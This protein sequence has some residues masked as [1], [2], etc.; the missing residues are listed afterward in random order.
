[1]K[2]VKPSVPACTGRVHATSR[3]RA[4]LQ[5]LAKE[6]LHYCRIE[7][8][9]APATLEAYGRDLRNLMDSMSTERCRSWKQLNFSLIT[10]HL[11]ALHQ[12]GLELTSIARHV[13]TIRVFCKYL[14]STHHI[15]SNPATLL[16]QPSRWQRLPS[17][18]SETD[19]EKLIQSPREDEPLG[20]RDRAIIELLYASGIRASEIAN[21]NLESLQ[22]NL[23]VAR[24]WGKGNRERI[25]PIGRPA[26]EAIRRY[27]ENLRPNLLKPEKP[28]DR[29]MLSRTGLP[30][31]RIV[32][33]Q[34]IKRHARRV[35]LAAVYPHLIRHSFAT[36]LLEGGADLRVVQELLGHA[37]I[38]T[39]QIYTHIDRRRLKQVIQQ[40]HPRG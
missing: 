16:T 22:D 40:F 29:L 3:D 30:I 32:V 31:T 7:C 37:N 17:V 9:F 6:F 2:P 36:H 8:G 11:E 26:L 4:A 20:L 10:L 23:A 24:I 35:G 14:E 38:R 27:L 12:R 15:P 18:L 39:T 21:L 5:P 34:I 33:W 1:M 13:A 28:T 19:M 25:V